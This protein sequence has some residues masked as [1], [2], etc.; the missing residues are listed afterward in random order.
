[1]CVCVCVSER[2]YGCFCMHCVGV[3]EYMSDCECDRCGYVHVYT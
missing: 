1:M 2:E 3:G